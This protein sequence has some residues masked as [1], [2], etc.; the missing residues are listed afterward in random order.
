MTNSILSKLIDKVSCGDH[1]KTQQEV[2][3][4]L[5]LYLYNR[6]IVYT[7]NKYTYPNIL[8]PP[9]FQIFNFISCDTSCDH[10]HVLFHCPRKEIEIENQIKEN[11]ENKNKRK[12]NNRV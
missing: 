5:L 6:Y 4:V 8:F 11:K 3:N 10:S 9:T 2:P 7:N 12:E 1:K